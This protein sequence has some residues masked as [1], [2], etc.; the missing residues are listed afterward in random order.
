VKT[1]VCAAEWNGKRGN[2]TAQQTIV[3][4]KKKVEPRLCVPGA[5][6]GQQGSRHLLAAGRDCQDDLNN[7]PTL[8]EGRLGDDA[9]QISWTT[10]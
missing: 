5:G 6:I 2:A 7:R 1:D 10:L 9:S 4:A 8:R 3:H